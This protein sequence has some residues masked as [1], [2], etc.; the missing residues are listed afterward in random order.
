[1]DG[2]LDQQKKQVQVE[3]AGKYLAHR[4][5]NELLFGKQQIG[6]ALEQVESV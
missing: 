5:G 4:R 2:G 1:L 3:D 6:W